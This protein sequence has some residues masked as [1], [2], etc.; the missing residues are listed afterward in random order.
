MQS[1]FALIE[2][3]DCLVVGLMALR[4]MSN[5]YPTLL[6]KEMQPLFV[7]RVIW[8]VSLFLFYTILR[9][10]VELSIKNKGLTRC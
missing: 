3:I 7:N 2:V 8:L 4:L 9:F 1:I 10:P 5:P 6:F